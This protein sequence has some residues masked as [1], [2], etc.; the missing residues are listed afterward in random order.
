MVGTRSRAIRRG[1]SRRSFSASP[2]GALACTADT[3][4]VSVYGRAT[5]DRAGARPE[6]VPT[7]AVERDLQG[8]PYV[9]AHVQRR[10]RGS[11][12]LPAPAERVGPMVATV[13]TNESTLT[14][15]KGLL[16]S[17]FLE[18]FLDMGAH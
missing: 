8:F 5:P 7:I 11:A 1:T 13:H 12:S 2:V 18:L 6:R 14:R 4:F 16:V 15:Y 10:T 17:P 9:D 3:V